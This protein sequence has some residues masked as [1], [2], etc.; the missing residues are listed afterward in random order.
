MVCDYSQRLLNDLLINTEIPK[1]RILFLHVKISSLK[2]E[3]SSD[4]IQLTQQIIKTMNLLYTPKT[5]LIPTFTYSFT[6]TGVYHKQFSKS[7]VGRFSEEARK[8]TTNRTND[9]I[10]NV[11]DIKSYLSGI[12]FD[13]TEAFGERSLFHYL[14]EED[15]IVINIGLDELISTQLHY[16]ERINNVPYRYNKTFHGVIYFN[17]NEWESLQ[18]KYFVRDL[19]KN[20]KWNRKKIKDYL[21]KQDALFFR[22]VNGVEVNWISAKT[23]NYLISKK[24]NEDNYFLL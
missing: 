11:V 1:N 18:Y 17:E 2:S 9:P 4:Y 20:V 8:A 12:D 15:C 24:L 6:K 10:F 19:G 5:I 3:S 7:E 23:M 14:N 16:I 22:T 21:V 13:Y